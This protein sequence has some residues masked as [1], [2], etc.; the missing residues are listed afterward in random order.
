VSGNEYLLSKITIKGVRKRPKTRSELFGKLYS[1]SSVRATVDFNTQPLS[2]NIASMLRTLPG[3]VSSSGASAGIGSLNIRIRGV[4]SNSSGEP[5]YLLDGFPTSSDVIAGLS[6][7][8]IDHL[9]L[10]AGTT[11]AFLYSGA[12][13]GAIA[14]YTRREFSTARR[15]VSQVDLLATKM[16]GFSRIKQFYSPLLTL[17]QWMIERH[18]IGIRRLLLI[19]PVIPLLDFILA[20]NQN[21]I[22]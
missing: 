11:A 20:T 6:P 14:I 12:S 7:Q 21:T 22:R 10:I 15:E 5:L 16:Q 1:E 18:C 2:Y 13:Y 3:V 9:D 17:C 4:N 8:E 19:M